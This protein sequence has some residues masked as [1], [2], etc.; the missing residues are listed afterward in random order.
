MSNQED[1]SCSTPDI[2]LINTAVLPT[3]T[4]TKDF[5]FNAFVAEL[6]G[7]ESLQGD[8]TLYVYEPPFP[9]ISEII[10]SEKEVFS[11]ITN[12]VRF[13]AEDVYNFI[14]TRYRPLDNTDTFATQASTITLTGC[15][16]D[17]DLYTYT[18]PNT[19]RDYIK[20]NNNN[21]VLLPIYDAYNQQVVFPLTDLNGKFLLVESVTGLD[22]TNKVVY[23][24][25][26]DNRNVFLKYPFRGID[27]K[28]IL[29]L[30]ENNNKLLYNV[31]E[32]YED[33]D[34]AYEKAKD[35]NAFKFVEYIVDLEDEHKI[36]FFYGPIVSPAS[37]YFFTIGVYN[38]SSAEADLID[39]T[40]NNLQYFL[41]YYP[42]R[43]E[44]VYSLYKN[45]EG[46]G[47][48][49]LI[50]PTSSTN[51]VDIIKYEK[52]RAAAFTS[53][54]VPYWSIQ[55]DNKISYVNNIINSS[56]VHTSILDIHTLA[57][58]T[59]KST[60]SL[61]NR[62]T[63]LETQLSSLSAQ[64]TSLYNFVGVLSTSVAY[65]S[66]VIDELVDP[67]NWGNLWFDTPAGYSRPIDPNPRPGPP[68]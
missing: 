5:D 10:Q 16:F 56:P 47:P 50:T 41:R 42:D 1:I 26:K 38:I 18:I 19:S 60:T 64:F 4:S 11:S 48:W 24:P 59:S 33:L 66:A 40:S 55:E 68:F 43:A 34:Y 58:S 67:L 15:T 35:A 2:N 28:L 23:F 12:D 44:Y 46:T 62:V 29:H 39:I 21:E 31:E 63:A 54:T 52:E 49:T 61:Q 51:V 25:L 14:F 36:G 45:Q 32:A 20:D 17:G 7:L 13:A 65:N 9:S 6:S 8:E 53:L 3:L 22:A 37:A 30:P 27:K 57:Q